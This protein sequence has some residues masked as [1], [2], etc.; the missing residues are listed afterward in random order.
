MEKKLRKISSSSKTSQR[1]DTW[2]MGVGHR[3]LII[4]SIDSNGDSL[5][6]TVYSASQN[7]NRASHYALNYN[8]NMDKRIQE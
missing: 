7:T 2:T 1:E 6:L 8:K 4:R 5:A 3:E